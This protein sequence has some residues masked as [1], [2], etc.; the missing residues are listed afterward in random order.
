MICFIDPGGYTVPYDYFYLKRLSESRRVLFVTSTSDRSDSFIESIERLPNVE[1]LNFSRNS[2]RKA[3][4]MIVFFKQLNFLRRNRNQIKTIH[5]NWAQTILPGILVLMYFRRRSILTVHNATP[6]DGNFI[7]IFANFLNYLFFSKLLLV[8]QTNRKRLVGMYPW[9]TR[10][11]YLI[12]H[13]LLSFPGMRS[14]L[15]ESKLNSNCIIFF[16]TV[17]KYKGIHILAQHFSTTEFSSLN[18]KIFGKWELKLTKPQVLN[19]IDIEDEYVPDEKI[20]ALLTA[21]TTF[22]LPYMND[23][24]SGVFY[25]IVNYGKIPICTNRGESYRLL[26]SVGLERLTFSLE[27]RK[28]LKKAITYA[29]SNQHFIKKRIAQLKI[30]LSWQVTMPKLVVNQ[31]YD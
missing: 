28:S 23:S 12:P 5:F 18:L 15:V 27:D 16:G 30:S 6:H 3:E 31:L 11:M 19:N 14:N 20:H 9:L 17:K 26:K 24:Q 13:G 1:V 8:S 22:I 7:T 2:N 29:Q 10:K 21:G 25:L 4:K